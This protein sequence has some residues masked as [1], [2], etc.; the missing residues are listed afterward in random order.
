MLII[1]SYMRKYLLYI[2]VF[3]QINLF[4]QEPQ[5]ITDSPFPYSEKPDTT[6]IINDNNC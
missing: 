2:L 3:T 5:R 1:E 4:S 6:Y